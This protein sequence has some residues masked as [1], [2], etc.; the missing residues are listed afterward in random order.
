MS[1]F[2]EE[3]YEVR[4]EFGSLAKVLILLRE[5]TFSLLISAVG[6]YIIVSNYARF[7]SLTMALQ[8]SLGIL[9]LTS[10]YHT[11]TCISSVFPL[12]CVLFLYIVFS[13]LCREIL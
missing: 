1:L 6:G 10:T 7:I 2:S 13:L 8:R 5:R 12:H 4:L 3:N 11:G 9:K